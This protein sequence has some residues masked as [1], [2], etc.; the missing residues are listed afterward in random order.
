MKR[1]VSI[2]KFII[3]IVVVAIVVVCGGYK[4]AISPVSKNDKEVIFEVTENST[5][6]TIAEKLK[7]NNLIRSINFYKVYIKIFKPNNLQKGTYKLNENMGVKGIIDKLESNDAVLD[8]TT[9]TIPEG[10]HIKDVAEVLETKTKYTKEE[11]LEYWNSDDFINEVI[12]KYWFITDDVKDNNLRYNLEGYFFPA[13]YEIFKNSTMKEISYKMLDKMD[14]VLSK[15]KDV[16]N[17]SKYSIHD[18]LTL[19]SIVEYEAILDNDR[20]MVA[21]VFLNRLDLGMK[22][23]SCATVGYA[24]DDWKL[25]YTYNDLQIDSPYNTYMYYGIPV[26]PGGLAGEAS[27]KAVLYPDDNDY[28]YFLANVYDS[29]ANKTYYS[30]TYSEHKEKCLLYL[31][32]AC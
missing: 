18:I 6:L 1:Y 13:T 32:R 28:L 14:E 21:K 10:K 27:I 11:W 29:N 7:E 30:K 8:T 3:A 12:T 2:Y 16:I 19:A 17:E 24:L 23:E 20:P 31:G 22:L 4:Y 5:Y 26:G 25:S 15:Y 9:F